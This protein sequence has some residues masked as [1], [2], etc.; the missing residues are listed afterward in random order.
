[1]PTDPSLPAAEHEPTR[2]RFTVT[3]PAGTA[4]LAYRMRSTRVLDAVTTFTPPE[5][6]GL[7]LAG[8][9]TRATLDHVRAEG[10]QVVTSCWYVDGWIARH[11]EYE[12][13]RA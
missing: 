9:V 4:Y 6:R 8:I 5:A 11:P 12:D 2:A 7:G 13:L 10:W 1:M 3:V